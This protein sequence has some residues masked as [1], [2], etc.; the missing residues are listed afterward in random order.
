MSTSATSRHRADLTFPIEHT[1]ARM[2][3]L[4]K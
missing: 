2:A 3:E 1:L 4:V